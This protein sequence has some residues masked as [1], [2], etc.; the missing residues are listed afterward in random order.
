MSYLS[1]PGIAAYDRGNISHI[2]TFSF[3]HL[4]GAVS[5][6]YL[7]IFWKDSELDG[8]VGGMGGRM[9]VYNHLFRDWFA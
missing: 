2:F 9:R 6:I 4:C 3:K 1:I 5:F 8:V 7:I